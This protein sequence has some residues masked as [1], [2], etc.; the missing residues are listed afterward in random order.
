M[1]ELK[2][3]PDDETK[4]TPKAAG[5]FQRGACNVQGWLGSDEESEFRAEPGRYH[6]FLNYGCG[7]SHQVLLVRALRELQDAVGVTHVGCFRM[8]QRGT[9]EYGG[10]AIEAGDTSGLGLTN[11]REVYN[12]ADGKYG[13]EQLTIPVLLDKKTKKVVSNDPAHILMMLDVLAEQL[14][15]GP[16]ASD[17][18]PL[19]PPDLR[20]DIEAIN[21]FV[22][23]GINNGVYCCWIRQ[24]E[25]AFQEGYD[26]VQKA[27]Q[28]L[29][30]HFS[31]NNYLVGGRLT[32][33]DVRAFPHLFR[34]D[35]I[36]FD[37]ML[38]GKGTRIFG[39]E[40]PQLPH[41]AAWLRRMFALSEVRSSCDLQVAT[42][43]Y[44]SS[45]PP[46]KADAIYD[47]ERELANAA[48][49]WLPACEDWAAKRESEGLVE[50]QVRNKL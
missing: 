24:T 27:L 14:R 16:H 28:D 42:R 18:D 44:Y 40:H 19:Y 5:S 13:V 43:F 21:D 45:S 39:G 50:A 30:K 29:E 22:Y 2:A 31:T 23:P 35:G 38:Q 33:A 36:Y 32:L 9:P 6:A 7:W 47:K 34:F 8:G 20:K 17:Q 4:F 41:V 15:G 10:Y 1:E 48:E 49:L 11:M 37:F 26:L 12:L 46:A 25:E 3:R